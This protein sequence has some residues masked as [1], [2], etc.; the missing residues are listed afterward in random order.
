MQ[1]PMPFRED[2]FPR[3]ENSVDPSQRV[4]YTV[5][6]V[7]VPLKTKSLRAQFNPG[8]VGFGIV[9]PFMHVPNMNEQPILNR[10][11]AEPSSGKTLEVRR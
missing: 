5:C 1:K 3:S 7:G 11:A 2:A 4:T 9:S 6:G 8:L 10:Q